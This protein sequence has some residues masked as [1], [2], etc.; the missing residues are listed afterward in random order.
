MGSPIKMKP[1]ML[2]HFPFK[3]VFL[4]DV[5]FVYILYRDFIPTGSMDRKCLLVKRL[6][7][8]EHQVIQTFENNNDNNNNNNDN[9]LFI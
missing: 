5:Y 2:I 4:Y 1:V 8:D 6:N 3:N 9:S 7:A